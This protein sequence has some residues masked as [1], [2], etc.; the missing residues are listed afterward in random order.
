MIRHFKT[1]AYTIER[2]ALSAEHQ[3]AKIEAMLS[4]IFD[5][6]ESQ[7]WSGRREWAVAR[8][9]AK[10]RSKMGSFIFLIN[11]KRKSRIEGC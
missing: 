7:P 11:V 6:P 3:Y 1:Q 10:T 9:F 5:V 2:T 8:R 4:R